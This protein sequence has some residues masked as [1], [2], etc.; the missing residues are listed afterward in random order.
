MDDIVHRALARWPNVPD[1][2]GW[3]TLDARG[4]WW[5]RDARLDHPA[6]LAFIAR[7]YQPDAQGAWFFQ[8]GPQRVFARLGAA[9]FVAR[10]APG[11]QTRPDTALL[12]HE[13]WLT[14]EGDLF[15]YAG[16]GRVALLD[17]RDL[18]R[19]DFLAADGH[20][21]DEAM[22][23]AGKIDGWHVRLADLQ[24]PLHAVDAATVPERGGFVRDP[25]PD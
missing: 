23:L 19:A 4:H 15:L 2:Y 13:A 3:L 24:L 16:P 18:A 21:G 14:A 25:Q 1:V 6:T 17:G 5:I 8:N 10:L 22:L 7:N 11:L 12:P 20:P 9:P